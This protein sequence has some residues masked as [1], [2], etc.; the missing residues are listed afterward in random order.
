MNYYQARQ[1]DPAADREDA[2]KWRYTRMNDGAI[3][4]HGVCAEGCPGH[5]TPEEACQHFMEG[6][7]ARGITWGDCSWTTCDNRPSCDKPARKVGYVGGPHHSGY[8]LCDDHAADN[9]AE[10]LYRLDHKGEFSSIASW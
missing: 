9:I 10:A 5:D 2:G 1:V 6:E 8:T 3:W 7:I 4:P